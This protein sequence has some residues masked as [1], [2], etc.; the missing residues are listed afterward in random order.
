MDVYIIGQN[1]RDMTVEI[2]EIFDQRVMLHNRIWEE[3]S[4]TALLDV[5]KEIEVEIWKTSKLD[6]GW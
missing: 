6:G 4:K 2:R 5:N 3:K 1:F